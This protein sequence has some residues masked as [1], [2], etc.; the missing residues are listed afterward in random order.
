MGNVGIN[1]KQDNEDLYSHINKP[2]PLLPRKSYADD[3]PKSH[4]PLK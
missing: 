3:K 4:Q 1:M 2:I